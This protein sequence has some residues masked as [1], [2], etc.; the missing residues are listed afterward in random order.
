M[1]F[2]VS[3]FSVPKKGHEP[4]DNQDAFWPLLA[5]RTQFNAERSQEWPS[6]SLIAGVAD[7]ATE[8]MFGEIWSRVIASR[9]EQIFP[10]CRLD[11]LIEDSSRAWLRFKRF[12]ARAGKSLTRLP[13]W[14]EEPGLEQGAF[15]TMVALSLAENHTWSAVAVGD[16]CLVHVRTDRLLLQ[17]PVQTSADFAKRPYLLCS[18]QGPSQQLDDNTHS[19]SNQWSEGDTF[20]IM[21]DALACWFIRKCEHGE[22]PWLPLL[23]LG[24][25]E[26]AG[27]FEDM[28][29]QW[30]VADELR[31]DDVTLIRI[32]VL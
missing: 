32:D 30:R 10:D 7:G 23:T 11:R 20:F 14:L 3:I 5:Q 31:N 24:A 8:G 9:L 2:F 21:S 17:W 1:A 29:A 25:N 27:S 18:E 4:K 15:S 16:S 28:V 6:A 19:I 12:K 13:A 26:A 22:K